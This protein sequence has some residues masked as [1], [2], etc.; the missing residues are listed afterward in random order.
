MKR[1]FYFCDVAGL[2][3]ELKIDLGTHL[4]TVLPELLP[5]NFNIAQVQQYEPRYTEVIPQEW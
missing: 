4:I 3:V 2:T 5:Q 1:W